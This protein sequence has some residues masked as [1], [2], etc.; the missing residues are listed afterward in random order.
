MTGKDVEIRIQCLDIV[1]KVLYR[2]GGIHQD[3]DIMGVGKPDD[4]FNRVDCPQRIGDLVD[5]HQARL[6]VEHTL[7][8]S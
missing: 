4:L 8:Q 1:L 7:K 5:C 2:L 6:L 3:G